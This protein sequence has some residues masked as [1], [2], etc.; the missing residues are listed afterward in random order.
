[1]RIFRHILIVTGAILVL[2]GIPVWSSGYIQG[3]LSGQDAISSATV[4]IEQPFYVIMIF[5]HCY[6]P[7]DKNSRIFVR[8]LDSFD[9]TLPGVRPVSDAISLLLSPPTMLSN[10]MLLSSSLS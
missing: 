2:V 10:T 9:R 8:L 5:A 4:M 7:Y 1:M 3:K 6:S